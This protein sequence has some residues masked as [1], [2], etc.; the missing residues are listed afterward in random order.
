MAR[1]ES[2]A[3]LLPQI[4]MSMAAYAPGITFAIN[5][6]KEEVVFDF[7]CYTICVFTYGIGDRPHDLYAERWNVEQK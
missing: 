2:H 7:D 3:E 5:E 4:E 6:K 1:A